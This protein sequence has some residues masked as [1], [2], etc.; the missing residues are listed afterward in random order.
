[1]SE[2]VNR[3]GQP[4]GPA[5]PDWSPPPSP[6]REALQGRFCRIEPLDAE[7]HAGDLFSALAYDPARWTYLP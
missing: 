7:R 2:R 5:L 3:Y 4:I 1:M 6:P